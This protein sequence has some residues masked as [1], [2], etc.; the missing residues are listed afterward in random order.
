[1]MMIVMMMLQISDA[2]DDNDDVFGRFASVRDV[3]A[4]LSVYNRLSIRVP[5]VSA[6]LQVLII[7]DIPLAIS[8]DVSGS[9]V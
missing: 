6:R 3:N 9:H 1:M 4:P 8:A 5:S 7:A 2:I